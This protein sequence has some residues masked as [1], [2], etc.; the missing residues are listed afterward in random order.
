MCVIKIFDYNIECE[1]LELMYLHIIYTVIGIYYRI[2]TSERVN[3]PS[4]TRLLHD[5]YYSSDVQ[6]HQYFSSAR[7][8]FYVTQINLAHIALTL[9]DVIV[10]F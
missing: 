7:R 10:E 4:V 1:P 5:Y 2:P 3:I 9:L 6:P 8:Y